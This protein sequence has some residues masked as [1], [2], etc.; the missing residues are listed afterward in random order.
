MTVV[1]Y[2]DILCSPGEC[3][4]WGGIPKNILS[5]LFVL[6]LCMQFKSVVCAFP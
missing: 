4:L 2:A 1:K 5:N 3:M 6:V